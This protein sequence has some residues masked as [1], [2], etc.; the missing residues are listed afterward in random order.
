M[1]YKK[2]TIEP[3]FLWSYWTKVNEIFTRYRGVIY[4]VNSHIAVVI[5][6]S[7]SK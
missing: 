6:Q 1:S 3:L 5:S 7:I 2:F 4:A